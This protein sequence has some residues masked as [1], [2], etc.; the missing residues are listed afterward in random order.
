MFIW[1]FKNVFQGGKNWV[2]CAPQFLKPLTLFITEICDFPYPTVALNRA[3][4]GWKEG[5]VI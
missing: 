1:Y 5:H 4:D 3:K 2:R